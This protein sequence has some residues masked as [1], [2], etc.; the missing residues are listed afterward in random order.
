MNERNNKIMPEEKAAIDW[1]LN[2]EYQGMKNIQIASSMFSQQEHIAL[3]QTYSESTLEKIVSQY[4]SREYHSLR[5]K[6]EGIIR[7]LGFP[8]LQALVSK[9]RSQTHGQS[10]ESDLVE[11]LFKRTVRDAEEAAIYLHDRQEFNLHSVGSVILVRDWM[12]ARGHPLPDHGYKSHQVVFEKTG[13]RLVAPEA[14]VS[15]E[16]RTDANNPKFVLSNMIPE[17]DVID[18]DVGSVI[19]E[20]DDTDWHTVSSTDSLIYLRNEEGRAARLRFGDHN[21]RKNRVPYNFTGLYLLRFADEEVFAMKR[22]SGVKYYP[23]SIDIS[24]G[25]QFKPEDFRDKSK[26]LL[27]WAYRTIFEEVFPF[28]DKRENEDERNA[29]I[30]QDFIRY[31]NLFGIG[32]HVLDCSFPLFIFIQSNWTSDQYTSFLRNLEDRKRSGAR[33]NYLLRVDKEGTRLLFTPRQIELFA[34]GFEVQPKIVFHQ[35]KGHEMLIERSGGAL[36]VQWKGD[37]VH[38]MTAMRLH[39]LF[40]ALDR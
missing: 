4:R 10:A 20:V 15:L 35:N 23:D 37:N 32:Y 8:N 13:K 14:L 26:V 18:A 19:L 25:E 33:N 2:V 24:G 36:P 5:S 21:P 16:P 30:D 17:L 9:Y 39:L 6:V 22:S 29:V 1:L 40:H 34:K 28:R 27:N 11:E 31:V 38:P 7:L 3:G 12:K